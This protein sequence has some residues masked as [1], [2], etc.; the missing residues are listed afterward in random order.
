MDLTILAPLA[1]VLALIFAGILASGIAK[2]DPGNERMQEIMG[3]IHEGAM[4]FLYREYKVLFIFIAVL[5]LIIGILL[6]SWL[7]ALC[8]IIGAIFSILAGYFGMQVATKAN[9]RTA[10]AAQ[11]GQNEAL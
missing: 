7:T 9:A 11:H 3:F 4:A 5:A 6:K 2:K 1:G 10:N 8:F